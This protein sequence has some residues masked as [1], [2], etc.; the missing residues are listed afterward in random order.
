MSTTYNRA[1][2]CPLDNN[3]CDLE[4]TDVLTLEP[5]ITDIMA[6]SES[7]DELLTVWTDWHFQSGRLMRDDYQEYVD[8]MQT[9]AEQNCK[10]NLQ[11]KLTNMIVLGKFYCLL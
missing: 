1:V 3:F 9:V 6:H 7:F 11:F 10:L 8:L 2:I 5:D 4:G